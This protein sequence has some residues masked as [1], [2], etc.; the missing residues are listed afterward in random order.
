MSKRDWTLFL[1][2]MPESIGNI[3]QHKRDEFS[4]LSEGYS[5]SGCSGEISRSHGRSGDEDS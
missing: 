2:D 3:A 4:G 1:Q 5:N